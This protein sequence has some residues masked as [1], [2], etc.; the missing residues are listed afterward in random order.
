MNAAPTFRCE[1]VTSFNTAA[2]LYRSRN[3][4][5]KRQ[6]V[7]ESSR[8]VAKRAT[9]Q[10]LANLLLCAGGYDEAANVRRCCRR[11]GYLTCGRHVQDKV[12]DYRCRFILCPDCATERQAR[13][14]RRLSPLLRDFQHRHPHDVPVM[15]TLTVASSY[16]SLSVVH[17]RFKKW[18]K[19]LRRS[20]RWENRIRA[21][22]CGFE[23]TYSATHGWHYHVH[24]L[25]FRKVWYPQ[26]E[27]SKQWQRITGS[28]VV[29]IREVK[30]RDVS[31]GLSEVLKYCFKPADVAVIGVQQVREWLDMKGARFGET[32]GDLVHWKLEDEADAG[33]HDRLTVGSP[34][35]DCGD[36]LR[37]EVSSR[38]DM[39][40]IM[41]GRLHSVRNKHGTI[42]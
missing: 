40:A 14:F 12:P 29:D 4:Q 31:A 2:L 15:I 19:R 33:D 24:V 17:K 3:V 13:A 30:G 5:G 25:A 36:P 10:H 9:K 16:D 37:F 38:E 27:L 26:E 35:P 20:K 22:V 32:I 21:G 1:S 34:C 6:G 41:A 23:V 39:E 42:H 28:M 18:F 7:S 8:M 11:F